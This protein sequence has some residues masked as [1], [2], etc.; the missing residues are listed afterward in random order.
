MSSKKYILQSITDLSQLSWQK[1][2]KKTRKIFLLYDFMKK[3]IN[4]F[5]DPGL[6]I[7]SRMLD[8]LQW[9]KGKTKSGHKKSSEK[10]QNNNRGR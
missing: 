9:R 5:M 7:L 3:D 1:L 6:F 8:R 4:M 2:N 10:L